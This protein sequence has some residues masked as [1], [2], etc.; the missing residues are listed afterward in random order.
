MTIEGVS[1]DK[2]QNFDAF[3]G[4]A[5]LEALAATLTGQN[6]TVQRHSSYH[7]SLKNHMHFI[8]H[9]RNPHVLFVAWYSGCGFQATAFLTTVPSAWQI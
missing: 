1:T 5:G 2:Y 6:S 7:F 8:C 9:A 3:T 4:D